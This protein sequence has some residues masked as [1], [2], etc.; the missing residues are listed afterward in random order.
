MRPPRNR[1]GRPGVGLAQG[2]RSRRTRLLFARRQYL[3]RLANTFPLAGGGSVPRNGR[4]AKPVYHRA[5]GRQSQDAL[6]GRL[7]DPNP[8]P[9]PR[10]G[11]ERDP[12]GLFAALR[13]PVLPQVVALPARQYRARRDL[14]PCPRGD[15]RR[16][17]HQHGIRERLPRDHRRRRAHLRDLPAH[18]VLRG[19]LQHRHGPA[20]AGSGLRLHRLHHHL[21]DLRLFHVHLLRPGSGD[22]GPGDRTLLRIT[23]RHRLRALLPR[24]HS[25]HFLRRHI[26]QS[27]AALDAALLGGTLHYAFLF[28]VRRGAGTAVR[29]VG[30]CRTRGGRRPLRLPPLRRCHRRP[31]FPRRSGGRAGRLPALP[32]RTHPA[33]PVA[34]VDRPHLRGT[35]LDSPGGDQDPCRQPACLRRHPPRR[36]PCRSGG[37]GTHVHRSLRVHV[38]RR[39]PR[40][41]RRHRLRHHLPGKDQRDQRL[42]GLARLG[43]LLLARHPLSP[44]TGDLAGVQ[45]ADRPAAD[46]A[47]NLRD[48]GGGAERLRERRERLGRRARCGSRGAQ[49]PS[50][51]PALY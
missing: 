10:L 18:H 22:H 30:V 25:H 41:P 13:G 6:R 33:K 12:G 39:R 46:A 19:P 32:A 44:G 35:R 34:L 28:R 4:V 21:T 23:H 48:A 3:P 20:D 47:R 42:R 31:V 2:H 9:L 11:R 29:M 5:A 49:A 37:A 24:D 16:D 50:R 1:P 45:R 43:Q 51:Q 14:L 27:P 7:R 15:R 26:D 17:H 8:A 38:R 36:Q 40:R